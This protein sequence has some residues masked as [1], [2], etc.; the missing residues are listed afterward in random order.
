MRQGP[1]ESRKK[2]LSNSDLA[3]AGTLGGASDLEKVGFEDSA[4]MVILRQLLC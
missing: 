4:T 3:N 2:Y 1:V